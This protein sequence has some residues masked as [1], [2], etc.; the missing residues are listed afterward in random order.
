MTRFAVLPG[1]EERAVAFGGRTWSLRFSS[2]LTPAICDAQ[3][4]PSPGVT[5]SLAGLFE[6]PTDKAWRTC[7]DVDSHLLGLAVHPRD[8]R[9]HL[10]APGFD[11]ERFVLAAAADDE[12]GREAWQ[13]HVAAWRNA[14]PHAAPL[15]IETVTARHKLPDLLNPE[16]DFAA[17]HASLLTRVKAEAE[18]VAEAMNAYRPGLF[19]R[20]SQFGLGLQADHAALRVNALRFVALLPSLDHDTRGTEIKR[21][22]LEMMRRVLEDSRRASDHDA[23]PLPGWLHAVFVVGH[24]VVGW[25]SPGLVARLTRVGL[26]KLARSFI[27][28][29]HIAE[30]QPALRALEAGGRCATLDQL[31]ELVVQ[32]SEADRYCERVLELVRGCG[33]SGQA[34][35]LNAADIPVGNVSVKVSALC[36]HYD[37]DDVEGT[38]GRVGPRLTR[39][40]QEARSRGV[41]IN[42]DAEHYAVRDLTFHMFT[43]L[44]A[45][46]GGLRDYPWIGIVVQAYLRDAAA[47]LEELLGFCRARGVRVPIRLVKGAYWDEETTEANA[48]GYDAPQFLNKAET[49][50]LFQQLSLRILQEGQVAQLCVGSHNLRDHC[51]ARAAREVLY[52]TAPPVEHQALHMTY[53]GLSTAMARLG[54]PVRNYVPV[55]SLLVGMAYLVRR[56]MENSSQVGVLT[57]ARGG[58]DLREV[59][60][61][62]GEM[63]RA[64]RS[65]GHIARHP[66]ALG[67]GDPPK[68]ANAAPARLYRPAH[69]RALQRAIEARELAPG[70]AARPPSRPFRSG[71]LHTSF[72]PS[73]AD[74]AVGV[75]QFARA[76]DVPAAVEAALEG[77]KLWAAH[78]VAARA[79][80]LARAAERMRARRLELAVLVGL[81]AGKAR[82]EA[83]ADVDEAIDF[84]QFYGR[85]AIRLEATDGGTL[86][87]RGVVAVIAPWN[88]PIAIPCGMT[89]AALAAGNAAILKSAE[90]TPLVAEALVD[91]LHE[92][93]VPQ[94]ALIHLPGEGPEV[95]APLVAHPAIAGCVF[96]GSKAVGTRIHAALTP[97]PDARGAKLVIT[98]MG[99]KNAVIVTANA[100]LDEAISGVLYGAF[101]HAGQKCSAAS[102][103]LV[104]RRVCDAFV[105]R[106]AGAAH[107]QKVG[108]AM[109]PGT[110]I[111]PVISDEDRRRLQQAA[112]DAKREA[113]ACGGRVL[114]DLSEAFEDA[115]GHLVGPVILQLPAQAAM[116]PDSSARQEHFGPV[117]HVIAFEN[118]EQAMT[119]FNST[120]YALT[121]GI[122]SQSMDDVE[123]LAGLA[124]C[125]NLYVN[126]SNTGA[127]V[128][129]EPFGGFKMSGTGPKAGGTAYLRAFYRRTSADEDLTPESPD[130]DVDALVK[131]ALERAD[132]LRTARPPTRRIPGQDNHDRLDHPR[133]A[134]CALV[135]GPDIAR[136]PL[137][138]IAAALATGNPV[139]VGLLGTDSAAWRGVLERLAGQER[140]GGRLQVK[141]LDEAGAAAWLGQVDPATLVVQGALSG[142]AE[143]LAAWLEARG[144]STHLPAVY[145]AGDGP[146]PSDWEGLLRAHLHCRTVALNTMRH[147]A[148][149][150]I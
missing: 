148:P 93:G 45:P 10:G 74:E 138:H 139:H 40:L 132:R 133:G 146:S 143:V 125:G 25:T 142:R 32:E 22:L 108:T 101:G 76:Q 26:R 85:E 70:S 115:P 44:L 103:V 5:A 86:A 117:V 13:A 64:L 62:P 116:A 97:R 66:T 123:Q 112:R 72:S 136:G 78:P 83:L 99:G 105:E 102:R 120:E 118:L 7:V 104:D 140:V 122:F 9:L 98:E 42:L 48:H 84:L 24:K 137:H 145:G 134:L 67:G 89:V 21:L 57:M 80:I 41:F 33:E 110:H 82:N 63:L 130:V 27:A 106:L 75:L 18:R 14:S 49:D 1:L 47:H 51:F 127:R 95:G 91:L 87:P 15:D 30:A 119:L 81:E 54:W 113:E 111:N 96:T 20:I 121:G 8:A 39:I 150:E 17:E 141:A 11:S 58:L 131:T 88:F 43:R 135:Q 50:V 34:P 35:R 144:E 107:D 90:Q 65:I 100:D 53:E 31:G 52:P 69:Q 16:A 37:P 3:G 4:A 77:Q 2:D 28:G 6:V 59:L 79:A 124:E 38:W 68:F 60:R 55:G 147:G 71:P 92:V 126:R 94:G 23:E 12:P 149:L 109:A 19:E 129:I 73:Q 114:V 61:T 29:E 46:A 56:I 36:A 128:A